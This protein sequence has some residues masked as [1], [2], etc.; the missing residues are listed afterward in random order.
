MHF[1]N[2]LLQNIVALISDHNPILLDTTPS[3]IQQQHSAL[4]LKIGGFLSRGCNG[5]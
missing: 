5:L 1:P 2:A 4:S 3:N